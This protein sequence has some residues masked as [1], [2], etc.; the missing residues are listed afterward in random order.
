MNRKGFTLFTA[1]I[2]LLLVSVA[3]ALIFNMIN[4]EDTYLS[5]IQDQSAMSDLMT[6][7]DLARADAFNT[8]IIT[9]RSNWE[10]HMSRHPMEVRR[11]QMDMNWDDFT[12]WFIKDNFFERA[13]PAY[14]AQGILFNL[15]YKMDP[16]GYDIRT[17]TN[18][19]TTI[20]CDEGCQYG[21]PGCCHLESASENEDAKDKFVSVVVDVFKAG[22]ERADVVD[23]GQNDTNCNGSFF[24]T[25]DTTQLAD[26]NYEL[27]PIV[28]VLRT[29]SNQVIQRPVLSR[30]IYKI[31]MPWRGLQ[32]LRT[33]RNIVLDNETERAVNPAD[34][35]NGNTG[36][37]SP[38]IHN[39]LEQARLGYCDPG[40]CLPREYFFRTPNKVGS[41]GKYCHEIPKTLHGDVPQGLLPIQQVNFGPNSNTSITYDDKH[42]IDYAFKELYSQSL[43]ANLV[44]NRHGQT[45]TYNNGL[46]MKGNIVLGQT[47]GA[48]D[49]NISEIE[50][51]AK[52]KKSKNYFTDVPGNY[53]DNYTQ[54]VFDNINQMPTLVGG[55]GLFLKEG[56]SAPIWEVNLGWYDEQNNITIQNNVAEQTELT[57]SEIDNAITILQFK[58]TDPRY[59][60]KDQYKDVNTN[61][62]I[63][64]RED[65]SEFYF[66]PDNN[67]SNLSV[68]DKGYLNPV[69]A[70]NFES[71]TIVSS[72]NGIQRWTCYSQVKG[73]DN[74]ACGPEKQ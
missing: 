62:E 58:E 64:L 36:F 73:G 69:S 20:V 31:Y 16:P 51:N 17:E 71:T 37:F 14:F 27:L 29:K 43:I 8:F 32:A 72:A 55:L 74:R 22:G 30:Q 1:L 25:L 23:C 50:V 28:T 65:F 26:E 39:T 21:D 38:K 13:F 68:I 56:K 63:R 46:I 7:A 60:I 34:P 15:K 54:T 40:T 4:T 47:Q 41:S 6:M 57:C 2:S 10:E 11:S 33:A 35:E 70:N 42:Q 61:I 49:I 52:S 44:N 3:L 45:I 66:T 9:L 5:L 24:L 48:P 53:N 67:W 59:I 19:G 12:Q 18:A